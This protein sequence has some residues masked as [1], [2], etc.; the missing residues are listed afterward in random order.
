MHK[1]EITS[2]FTLMHLFIYYKPAHLTITEKT[3]RLHAI[4]LLK[5]TD[6]QLEDAIATNG[7]AMFQ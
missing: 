3:A 6:V 7:H 2:V 4:H 5:D 1:Q